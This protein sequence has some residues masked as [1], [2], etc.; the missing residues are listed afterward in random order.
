M[1]LFQK[2]PQAQTSAPLY[3]VSANKTLLIVGLGNP[4]EKYDGTRHNAGFSA[5]DY[6]AAQNEFPGWVVKKDLKCAIAINRLGENRVV[7]CKPM[8]FMNLSGEAAH[9]V[10]LYYRVANHQSLV[11]YDELAIPFG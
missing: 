10:Q 4:D 6:F 1:A 5:I 2:N 8:T 7:L 11:I 3:T 9:A